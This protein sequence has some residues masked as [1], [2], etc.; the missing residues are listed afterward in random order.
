MA[1]DI[2]ELLI[3]LALAASAAIVLVLVTRRSVRRLAG[4]GAAYHSWLVVLAAMAAAA[5]PSLREAPVAA[6]ALAPS[7]STSTLVAQAAPAGTAWLTLALL[8]WAAGALATAGVLLAGQRRYVRGLGTLTRRGDLFVAATAHG[9]P[10][11]LGLWRPIVV[12]PSDFATRYS[13]AEQALIIAH[14]K[15]H[16]ERGDPAVNALLALLQ[17]ALWFN[18][19]IHIAAAR[20]RFD[21]E[22]A[23]DAAV[24][25]RAYGQRQTYA[26]AM[27]KTQATGAAALATCHWQSS[28]PLKER[29]MQLKQPPI[30]TPRRHAG[31]TI[32][33]MLACAS[34]LAT[35]A[36]R[37]DTAP[38]GGDYEIAVQFA[39]GADSAAPPMS[40]KAGEPLKLNW[41]QEGYGWSGD[42][43]V[44]PAKDDMVFVKL[45]ITQ[46]NGAKLTPAVMARLG[47]NAAVKSSKPGEPTFSVSFKVT[48]PGA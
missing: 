1:H 25:A 39:E 47:E 24:L 18:P 28:H 2:M 22:L 23:C 44:T 29:I 35:V 13:Q 32:V 31:R 20:V 12:V 46:E 16:A 48:R 6:L 40:V 5:L 3:R 38:A 21:Q 15:L 36:A 11:L 8:A 17:C 42:F 10:A 41:K 45:N 34:V 30:S 26:A 37:A 14:E 7:I 9:G 19:L 4:A 43:T 27:L 33:A